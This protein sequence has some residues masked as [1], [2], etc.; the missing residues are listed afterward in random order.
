MRNDFLRVCLMSFG[1]CVYLLSL[2]CRSS[3]IKTLASSPSDPITR[4]VMT[5]H[6]FQPELIEAT[7]A[8]VAELS[9]PAGF[10]IEKFADKLGKPRMLAVRADGT[11]YV[12]RRE[13]DVWMLRDADGDGKA[14]QRKM[15]LT[16]KGIHGMALRSDDDLYLVAVNEVVRTRLKPDGSFGP[17]DTIATDLP[18]GGQHANRTLAFSPNGKLYVS[19][20]STCNACDETSEESATLLEMNPDGTGRRIYARGLQKKLQSQCHL[21]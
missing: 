16:Y 3:S 17:L 13:G 11:T 6:V 12:T 8:R 20:G 19:V 1:L 21:C 14:E 7:D 9:V 15:V 4:A 5:G 2:G 10:R 18:D